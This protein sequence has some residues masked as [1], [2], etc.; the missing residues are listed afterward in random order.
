M[1]F[2]ESISI[3]IIFFVYIIKT[4]N[5][6]QSLMKN[7]I[8]FAPLKKIVVKPIETSIYLFGL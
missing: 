7:G 1:F 2:H 5:Q 6:I 3:S 8:F 4:P